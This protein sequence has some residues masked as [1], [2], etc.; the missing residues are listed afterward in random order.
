M[1]RKSIERVYL[2][3]RVRDWLLEDGISDGGDPLVNEVDHPALAGHHEL[4]VL[5]GR[6]DPISA[7]HEKS[8][9]LRPNHRANFVGR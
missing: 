5:S 6:L 3:E 2:E 8:S 1:Q 7:G 4:L 9:R